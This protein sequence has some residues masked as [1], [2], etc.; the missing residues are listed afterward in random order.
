METS[1]KKNINR[2]R[3]AIKTNCFSDFKNALGKIKNTDLLLK[4]GSLLVLS[5]G[6]E[7]EA[8]VRALLKKGFDVNSRSKYQKTALMKG[9]EHGHLN[10]VKLLLEYKA[11][12]N[13]ID[14]YNCSALHESV[15]KGNDCIDKSLLTHNADVNLNVDMVKLLVD[16]D[17]DV[18]YGEECTPL[19]KACVDECL[20]IVNLLVDAKANVNIQDSYGDTPLYISV[21]NGNIDIVNRLLKAGAN[22]NLESNY[23]VSPQYCSI[24]FKNRNIEKKQGRS[25]PLFQA[26]NKGFFEITKALID[27]GADL[28]FKNDEGETA[29]C[30]SI[31]KRH[32]HIVKVLIEQGA[33]VNHH[34]DRTAETALLYS[35]RGCPSEI[36]KLLFQKGADVNWVNTEGNN[37]LILALNAEHIKTVDILLENNRQ[38]PNNL[39]TCVLN[40]VSSATVTNK[41]GRTIFMLAAMKGNNKVLIDI[42]EYSDPSKFDVYGNTAF[43]LAAINGHLDIV[44][45]LYEGTVDVNFKGQNA[46]MLAAIGGHVNVVKWLIFKG[47]NVNKTD[48]HGNTALML[49]GKPEV[50]EVLLKYKTDVNVINCDGRNA[51]ME[52]LSN[53]SLQEYNV[54]NIENDS[55][56]LTLLLKRTTDINLRD[57]IGQ[58]A[59]MKLLKNNQ[60]INLV[61]IILKQHPDVNVKDNEGITPLMI[62]IIS[63]FLSDKKKALMKSLKSIKLLLANSND[64]INYIDKE[65]NSALMWVFKTDIFK[66]KALVQ[67]LLRHGADINHRNNNKTSVLMLAVQKGFIPEGRYRDIDMG[68]SEGKTA[69]M[70]AVETSYNSHIVLQLLEQHKADVNVVDN[71]G[72]TALMYAVVGEW[73]NK[74]VVRQLLEHHT[75]DVNVVDN[76]G[77]T[78]L[79]YAVVEQWRNKDIVR[80]L[81]EHHKV[82]VNVVDNKGKTA[83]MYAVETWPNKHVRQLLEHHMTD[84][85]FVDNTGETAL[86]K[87]V[88]EG[89]LDYVLILLEH[90]ADI[91]IQDKQGRTALMWVAKG[92]SN[93]YFSRDITR[94]L[95]ETEPSDQN[96][97][98]VSSHMSAIDQ[99]DNKGR[100]VLMWATKCCDLKVMEYLLGSGVSV[101]Q[102]DAAVKNILITT[103]TRKIYYK[104][105]NLTASGINLCMNFTSDFPKMSKSILSRAKNETY[106]DLVDKY[107]NTL[108]MLYARQEGFSNFRYNENILLKIKQDINAVNKHNKT[109]LMIALENRKYEFIKQVCKLYKEDDVV[110]PKGR[111]LLMMAAQA[112]LVDTVKYLVSKGSKVNRVDKKQRTALIHC[113]LDAP[114]KNTF[115]IVEFLLTHGTNVNSYDYKHETVLIKILK[116]RIDEYIF[117]IVKYLLDHNAQTQVVDRD[118]R[119]PLMIAI[120]QLGQINTQNQYYNKQEQ[121]R[122]LNEVIHLVIEKTD[123]VNTTDNKGNTALMLA[124]KYGLN[125][126]VQILINKTDDINRVNTIGQTSYDLALKNGHYSVVQTLVENK[127]KVNTNDV[128][129]FVSVFSGLH[130][131]HQK[132]NCPENG[133]RD[134]ELWTAFLNKLDQQSALATNRGE[135]STRHIYTSGE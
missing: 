26:C 106:F 61:K 45:L 14:N 89:R 63:T 2:I 31:I 84:V 25:S 55:K 13:L 52:I 41:L 66:S 107:S 98:Q 36:V 97:H 54:Y 81:L 11:D 122:L 125:Y 24:S 87:A 46:L 83:L 86:I 128:L 70:Y 76:E 35:A 57:Y 12:V 88:K 67:E 29:L 6:L 43:M 40:L 77:K 123:D 93:Q 60:G 44:Q 103:I 32:F 34:V 23:R 18:N 135:N 92:Y 134:I 20:E 115:S 21:M 80:Q 75:V 101:S 74:H 96:T 132:S 78:A 15:R 27:A 91:Y 127:A 120:I 95:L 56:W 50:V 49:A 3:A 124:S 53:Y 30:R 105:C 37:A 104:Y 33:D 8:F 110:C 22:V 38:T 100:T 129:E 94:I 73:R 65:G 51:L 113:A 72:K 62:A 131:L 99:T 1:D 114:I 59:I 85:N 7:N 121:L 130:K 42:K 5:A 39:G 119:S 102:I 58:T 16:H 64:S 108:L 71:K 10:V 48:Y 112:G 68:D 133:T 47:F 28:N 9:A 126:V 118:G 117:P 69:L 4:K 17:A 19:Y 90:K 82:D 111:T 109:A 79:M 116:R